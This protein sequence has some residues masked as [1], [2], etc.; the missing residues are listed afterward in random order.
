M[1]AGA[2]LL[3]LSALESSGS[4]ALC[5]DCPALAGSWLLLVEIGAQF[6]RWVH[7]NLSAY[8]LCKPL[9]WTGPPYFELA[10]PEDFA[11]SLQAS[12]G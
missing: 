2:S 6:S 4:Y 7:S 8:M 12:L 5:F 10:P 9:A 3:S 1:Q 11:L